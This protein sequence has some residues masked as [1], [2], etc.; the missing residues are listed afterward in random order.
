MHDS[1][2]RLKKSMMT[3]VTFGHCVWIILRAMPSSAVRQAQANIRLWFWGIAVAKW[4]HRWFAC[5][6]VLHP[7]VRGNV[8]G[9]I[10]GV[11]CEQ[12]SKKSF[13]RN[14]A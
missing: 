7:S 14:D 5:V 11:C 12:V 8:K 6:S 3:Q 2:A 1:R 4:L 10:V 9:K 13:E